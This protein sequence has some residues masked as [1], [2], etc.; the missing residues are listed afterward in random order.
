MVIQHLSHMRCGFSDIEQASMLAEA[1]YDGDLRLRFQRW[2]HEG[3]G[4]R[5]DP[6]A[7]VNDVNPGYM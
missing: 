4:G 2:K 7:T 3:K 5:G 1:S 6:L